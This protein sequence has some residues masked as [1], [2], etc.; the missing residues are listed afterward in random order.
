MKKIILG[1]A[2]VFS[3]AMA[4]SQFEGLI[5]EKTTMS[6]QAVAAGAPAGA[7]AYRVF[8][9]MTPDYEM[10][11][12]FSLSNHEMFFETT[13]EFYNHPDGVAF[14]R[15]MTN[16]VFN[17]S[18]GR[19]D[20]YVTVDGVTSSR[21]GILKSEDPDGA[22]NGL[23]YT[24]G[25]SL[26]LQTVGDDFEVPFG[27]VNYAGR[28]STFA[29][30]YN[31]NGGEQG[32]TA[33]NRVLIGQFTTT[34][35]FS[36]EINIQMRHVTTG[37]GARYVARDPQG[38]EILDTRL[39]YTSL[40][41]PPVVNI[42]SPIDGAAFNTGASV[43]IQASVTAGDTPTDSIQVLVDG[44][45]IASFTSSPISTSW[46]ATEGSHTITVRAY[47]NDG[48][49]G[50]DQAIISVT[51]PANPAPSVNLTAPAA[52]NYPLGAAITLRATASDNSAVTSVI[53][54]VNNVSVGSGTLVSG[55]AQS[56]TW[57][58]SWT[59]TLG[60]SSITAVATDDGSRSTES[61]PAVNIYVYDPSS[62]YE[63]RT[64]SNLCSSSDVFCMTINAT[65]AIDN[66]IGF[67][68]V[69]KFDSAIVRPTGVVYVKEELIANED[70]TST[71]VNISDADSMFI[72]LYLNGLAPV[73]TEFN[74][75]GQLICVEFVKTH[76]FN[77]VD[78]SV[79]SINNIF[80]SYP[81]QVVP[82]VVSNGSYISYVDDRFVGSLKFWKD[83]SPMAFVD[84]VNLPTNV[85]PSTACNISTTSFVRPDAFGIFEYSTA[86]GNI[87]K[88]KRDIASST[89]VQSVINGA[90]HVLAARVTINDETFKPS[91]YQMIAMD[92]NRDGKVSAGDISQ[93]QQRTVRNI[94][95]Y[96]Q[97]WNY[98]DDGTK[99][100]SGLSQDWVFVP[101]AE[102]FTRSYRISQNYPLA[103]NDGG[104][105][106][107][108]VPVSDTCY[109]V[110]ITGTECP[111]I[112]S[113]TF[114]GILLGDVNGSYMSLPASPALKSTEE[115]SVVVD[116]SNAL[117][118]DKYIDVPVYL[119]TGK[120][121]NAL[122]FALELSEDVSF[123]SI[124][125]KVSSINGMAH[126]DNA[127]HKLRFTS[128]SLVEYNKNT[129]LVSIRFN[130]N[131]SELNSSN[132][133]ATSAYINGEP[134][135][136]SLK[137]TV[138][139]ATK[140]ESISIYPNPA[141][142]VINVIVPEKSTIQIIDI[143]GKNVL[144]E[145]LVNA[146]ERQEI[147]VIN[148]PAGMYLVKIS[149]ANFTEFKQIAITK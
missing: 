109:M 59:P 137:G 18:A 1:L 19:Y 133:N 78:T 97:V 140:T 43:S 91:I 115:T 6:P 131:S 88:I 3:T 123:N 57:E 64:Q 104:V 89:D 34:G 52:G 8:V 11:A 37:A 143:N 39:R 129:Q 56:G 48:N 121:V 15:T 116:L 93:M 70:W 22:T 47:E 106:K 51:T 42:T 21:V 80:E 74:G 92:V 149:N 108:N 5:V 9:D 81:T 84:G 23:G 148:L 103:D 83:N 14:G 25:T 98:N 144:L 90:D 134:V 28:W 4:F 36:F 58:Y 26:A 114:Q 85:Y 99:K 138:A 118:S 12:V 31:V 126:F 49:I 65:S 119:T 107:N 2:L 127:D 7:V 32:L 24:A 71:A 132:L 142:H 62:A 53:F 10:Q 44:A 13:T 27:A 110:N 130:K 111:I 101:S 38:T 46:T 139:G 35:V 55:N 125:N 102:A 76:K 122:D 136:I 77:A 112:E 135:K 87:I 67:D 41:L 45:R 16:G 124:V 141:Q 128:Y 69:M 117:V 54:E 75:S 17:D 72:S 61:A 147:S 73:G 95:E 100:N 94:T 60:A 120:K 50:E 113:E 82:K 20:T 79:F 68:M 105:T 96:Q 86:L 146:N 30:I 29:G 145:T 33:N 63:I 66:V 40:V